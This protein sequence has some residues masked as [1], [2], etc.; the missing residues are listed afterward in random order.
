MRRCVLCWMF[1]GLCLAGPAPEGRTWSGP[2]PP[3]FEP[4]A[5]GS[6]EAR[7]LGHFPEYLAEFRPAEVRLR[8][9]D[10]GALRIRWEGGRRETAVEGEGRA[11]SRS[12]YFL[13]RGPEQWRLDVP[14]Y[15]AVRYREL[16][17][18]I[19]A[20][21]YAA[22]PSLE[23]DLEIAPGADPSTVRLRFEGA[24]GVR[25][26]PQGDLEIRAGRHRLLHK[27]PVAWQTG[28]QRRDPVPCRYRLLGNNRVGIE[29]GP[30]DASRTLVVD[31]VLVYAT[32]FGTVTND[33]IIGVRVDG[34][35]A[36]YIAGYT[37]SGDFA[38]TA[39]AAQTSGAGKR[40]I[41][42]A[43]LDLSKEGLDALSY[44]TYLGGSEADTPNAIEVDAEGNVYLTGWTQSTDFPLGGN[45]PQVNRAGDTGQDAFVVKLNPAIPGPFALVFSTYLGGSDSDT[46]YAIASDAAGNI[47]VAGVTRSEDFPVKEKVLQRGR[48][49][50]QDGFIVWLDPNAPEPGAVI[51]YSSYIGGEYN[52]Q[53]R[54][55]VAL[56]PGL[57][58]VAGET[59]S[60]LYHV[61]GDA[62][63][64][65]YQQGG[66]V[67]LTV[68]D[69]NRPEYDALVYSSYLGGSGSEA[70]RRMVKGRNGELVL[71][72]YT[73]STDFP[74]TPTALQP[75][76]RRPGQA[77][78]TILDPSRPG[79]QGLLYSTYFGA[80]GG[81]VAYDVA[82]D[83]K[84]WIY[85]TGYTL[86]PDFPVTPQAAQKDFGE[87]VEAFC[88]IFDPAVAGPAALKYATY[89]G[90]AGVN[91]GYGIAVGPDGTI[92]VAGSLQDR[93]FPVS[94]GALQ[95]RHAGGLADGFL[96]A[97]KPGETGG[98]AGGQRIN[99]QSP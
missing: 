37:S 63:R 8:F 65:S 15:R 33:T 91:V 26:T 40:D 44:F 16:Y 90:R 82:L 50:D 83:S 46:G 10:G 96:V 75:A 36:V 23:Y 41:F 67:F 7:F 86:S 85:L 18:G 3:R 25:M 99:M 54:A 79:E 80:S 60:Q 53:V 47:Y 98:G 39:D 62:L 4:A 77:F 76:P 11:A 5:S 1:A 88:A 6:G 34:K 32:Y 22:G 93:N 49:G 45:A 56:G 74:V 28:R 42:V 71:T 97:L 94:P 35:G 57:V 72:G 29:V 59:S 84:G 78:V 48:W 92:Y 87:G 73:L 64:A 17:P 69:M 43:R 68:L 24:E 27:K 95:P 70:P 9:K 55:V 51:R 12:D 52:D 61:S 20:R 31:P 89:L 14:V 19:A 58:A 2:I 66:D 81:E 21:F 38:V 30:Y 13:G